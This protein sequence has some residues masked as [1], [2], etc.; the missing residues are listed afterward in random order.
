M[1]IVL[2]G[3]TGYTGRLA[4]ETM[5]RAGLAPTLAGRRHDDLVRL[6]DRLAPLAPSPQ[7]EPG[8]AV[9]DATDSA[10]VRTLLHDGDD[11]LVSTV[12]P[13]M[14]L[15]TAAVA[16]AVDAG[17]GYLDSAGE[18][19]FIRSI[20]QE[21]GPRAEE[22]GA[23]LIPAFGYDYVPGNLAGAIVCARARETGHTPTRVDVGYFVDGEFGLSSGTKASA[24]GVMLS[25]S[26]SFR[27][28]QLLK[29][30][31][32]GTRSFDVGR[33]RSWKAMPVAGSEHFGLPRVESDLTDVGVW[34]GWAGRW[35][36]A[37]A[38]A[39]QVA[40]SLAAIPGIDS[41]VTA[42]RR[43][44]A[45]TTG[46]GP[47]SAARG[48]ARTLVVAEATDAVG[49]PLGTVCLTGPSPYDLTAELLAWG[50]VSLATKGVSPGAHG[51]V[52]AFGLDVVER[53]CAD[54]GL[55]AIT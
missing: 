38:V 55:I 19:P 46:Q 6:A 26:F 49:R 39:G 42:L 2:L 47:D 29:G 32:S 33:N 51:P 31:P 5:V 10:S 54:M 18:P 35:T 25:P 34:L 24:A 28:G 11:V 4:A 41:G 3:A 16:A 17:A 13:F 1:R 45:K 9:A 40:G 21:W 27:Q 14:E 7:T 20:F 44:L 48:R 12:G 22:T 36:P 30:N 53:G 50:A 15:G 43:R 8:I 37:A 52:D 23:R